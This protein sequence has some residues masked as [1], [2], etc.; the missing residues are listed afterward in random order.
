MLLKEWEVLKERLK[1]NRIIVSNFGYLSLLQF[2]NLVLPLAY[3]P[4]LIRTIGTELFGKIVF[5]QT[6]MTYFS[7][8]IN[9]GFNISATKKISEQR[10]NKIALDRT[11]STV[12]LLKFLIWLSCLFVLLGMTF[13]LKQLRQDTLLYWFS[14]GICF[15]ELFFS[16]FYFQGIEKMRYITII[17]SLPKIF[18]FV[19]IFVFVKSSEDYILVPLFNSI[20]VIIGGIVSLSILTRKESIHFVIPDVK[21]IIRTFCEALPF[22]A[23]RISTLITSKTTTL[24][25][26][27]KLTFSDVAY[28]DFII[29]L[30]TV[31]MIPFDII[32]QVIYPRISYTKQIGVIKKII[33]FSV[34]ALLMLSIGCYFSS[35]WIMKIVLGEVVPIVRTYFIALFFLLPVNVASNFLGNTVLVVK[36]F[37]ADFN[38][39][40]IFSML[41]YLAQITVVLLFLDFNLYIAFGVVILAELFCLIYREYV[42][43]KNNLL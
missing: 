33:S 38:K 6:I 36:G 11:V 24:L 19:L 41:F 18:L 4:Y 2:I 32:N 21:E 7:M 13:L 25:I 40:V 26:G 3:Y 10:D 12:L 15:N 34:T 23:S 43:F 35:D 9:F 16:Q 30:Y 42:V 17:T 29:K 8:C 22:F 39:S 5:A 14:F 31:L 27:V 20:G 1:N 37:S 28:Y